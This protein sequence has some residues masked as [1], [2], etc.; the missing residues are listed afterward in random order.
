MKVRY[1]GGR[2]VLIKGPA[3]G[4]DYRFSGVETLQLVDPRDAIVMVKNP[5]FRIEGVVEVATPGSAGGR[6][7]NA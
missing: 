3:T 1:G 6:A 4:I 7:S 2:P 5:V